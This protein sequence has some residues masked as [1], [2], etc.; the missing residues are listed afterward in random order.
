[1]NRKYVIS[2]MSKDRTGIISDI[3]TVIFN[4]GG[5]LKD[6]N[7]S[8]LD[9]YFSMILIAEFNDAVSKENLLDAFIKIES[10][11][12][13][14]AV[15]KEFSDNKID[16]T[17]SSPE[18]TYVLTAQAK[19]R[20]GLVR[21]L[22]EFFYNKNINVLDLVTAHD[23]VL[24]TMIFQVDLSSV[25]SMKDLRNELSILEKNEQLE[26]VLQHND[27]YKATNEVG[28]PLDTLLEN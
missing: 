6:L 26:L 19:N 23:D 11:T 3:T 22:G 1:M 27:I 10:D 15:V 2:V 18:E 5:D 25:R 21:L 12:A 14:E 17:E 28:A 7:Q 8:V 4:L 20:K 24:Y 9:G 16:D 13:L